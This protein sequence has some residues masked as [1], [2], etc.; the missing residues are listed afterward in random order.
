VDEVGG[1]FPSSGSYPVIAGGLVHV[2]SKWGAQSRAIADGSP[3]EQKAEPQ[4]CTAQDYLGVD[5]VLVAWLRCKAGDEVLWILAG[6]DENVKP[7]WGWIHPER[8]PQRPELQS[9]LSVDPLLVVF[10]PDRTRQEI[11][12]VE[13][14]IGSPDEPGTHSVVTTSSEKV[15]RPCLG[16]DQ[17]LGLS[18][19]AQ[20][21]VG[22]GVVYLRSLL[23]ANGRRKGIIAVDIGTGAERWHARA[24]GELSLSPLRV[25]EEGRLI[26]YQAQSEL[27]AEQ[28][29]PGV[30]VALDPGNGS[31]T[32]LAALPMIEG[33]AE[34]EFVVENTDLGP[35]ILEWRDGRLAFVVETVTV[36]KEDGGGGAGSLATLV[37]S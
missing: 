37:F 9:V 1:E 6:Y 32:A 14:G 35:N 5:G 18:V 19:C 22:D 17:G 34:W 10:S 26:A 7:L 4:G 2:A 8:T 15:G 13:P 30:V 12:R 21:V 24:D 25:D 29:T 23:D 28:E 33:G 31:L 27:G 20:V 16:A 3:S 11:W 36:T